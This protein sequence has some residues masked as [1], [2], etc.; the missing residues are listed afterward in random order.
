M[1]I[2][3][4]GTGNKFFSYFS[5]CIPALVFY[6]V[7]YVYPTLSGFYYSTTDWTNMKNGMNFIGL[8][9]FIMIFSDRDL[10]NAFIVTCIYTVIMCVL[11]NIAGV[12]LALAISSPLKT[13]NIYR[14]IIF[15]P[16]IL[17]T[18][19]SSNIWVYMYNPLNGLFSI[20]SRSLGFGTLD[21]L[22]NPKTAL[23]GVI[24]T[25]LWQLIGFS[26]IIY[27]AALQSIPQSLMESAQID[28]VGIINSF[29]YIKLP[30]IIPAVTV[31]ITYSLINGLKVFDYIY[32]MTG[33]GP[34]K[35]TQTISAEVYFT[36]FNKGMFGYAS[37]MG[38][39]LFVFIAFISFLFL[40]FIRKQEVEA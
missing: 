16:Y 20:I 8:Q 7:F 32:L 37:S 15:L 27:Y 17:P 21:I 30:M 31:N 10:I 12:V 3:H 28:G 1:S 19:V 2:P 39:M 33:G 14:G 13:K 26:M 34:G 6:V 29:F 36:A 40:T 4:K 11:Q 9:N 22:G 5:F 38:V 24:A 35:T 25:N 18:V 23:L